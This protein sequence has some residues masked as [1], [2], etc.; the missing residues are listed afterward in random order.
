MKLDTYLRRDGA[1]SLT[2]LAERVGVSKARLSQLRKEPE[3]APDMALK[4]E[5]ATDGAL[6]ASEMS[7]IVAQARSGMAA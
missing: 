2:E 4:L 1:L 6:N 7:K 5:G 3:I